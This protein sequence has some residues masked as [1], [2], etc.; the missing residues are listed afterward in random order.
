MLSARLLGPA[1]RGEASLLIATVN[2]LMYISGIVGGPSIINHCKKIALKQFMKRYY[3]LVFAILLFINILLYCFGVIGSHTLFHQFILSTLLAYYTGHQYLLIGFNRIKEYN[4]SQILQGLLPL[5]VL[6]WG[7]YIQPLV[8]FEFQYFLMATYVSFLIPLLYSMAITSQYIFYK[9][10]EKDKNDEPKPTW[11]MQEFIKSGMISQFSNIIQ[12]FNYR[13]IFYI[14][15]AIYIDKSI[16]G[17]YALSVALSESIWIIGRSIGLVQLGSFLNM[18]TVM[19]QKKSHTIKLAVIG[20]L[21]SA[22]AMIILC[23]I[24]QEYIQY[25]VGEK[26]MQ[27]HQLLMVLAPAT[28][29][30]SFQIS[31]SSFFASLNQYNIANKASIISLLIL[32]S[33]SYYLIAHY[34]TDGAAIA[35]FL[36]YASSAIFF[37]IKFYKFQTK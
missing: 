31:I 21:L 5:L 3:L 7:Y 29:A 28:I 20:G 8:G 34:G 12:F 33:S 16:L 17:E 32:S 36:G 22:L 25:L 30:F 10:T 6:I 27:T 19:T 9:H 11:Q 24:P 15:G 1:L 4:T 13:L 26:Y 37:Y 35:S 2:I 18:E 14:L 23:L